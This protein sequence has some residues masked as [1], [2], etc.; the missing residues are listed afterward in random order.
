MECERK[1][2]TADSANAFVE[3]RKWKMLAAE[4]ALFRTALHGL[5]PGRV[6]Q[7]FKFW[8]HP[9]FRNRK[10]NLR[11]L[12]HSVKHAAINNQ[13]SRFPCVVEFPKLFPCVPRP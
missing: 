2:S 7:A 6:A 13:S 11:R 8:Q 4:K 1:S 12:G 3:N 10:E 5:S 9:P